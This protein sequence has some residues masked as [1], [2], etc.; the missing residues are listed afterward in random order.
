MAEFK[1]LV[2]I[3]NTDLKGEKAIVYALKDVRGIGVPFAHAVCVTLGIDGLAKIGNIAE[4]DMKRIDEVIKS[5]AKYNI[6]SWMFNRRHDIDTGEDKHVVTNELLFNKDNDIKLMPVR[7]Q[8]TRSNFRAN[9]GKV[10][11]VKTAGKKKA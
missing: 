1:H 4:T 2:R 5:P 10:V 7:G 11:G 8:R 9:K 6:P 3:A